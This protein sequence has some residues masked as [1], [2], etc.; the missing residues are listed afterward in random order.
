MRHLLIE[1]PLSKQ[2]WQDALA[3]LRS[4][5]DASLFNWLAEVTPATPKQLREGLATTALLLPWM[6]WKD[7]NNRVFD[8]A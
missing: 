3:W 2:I 7:M 8:R 1:C 4:N 6:I 5:N